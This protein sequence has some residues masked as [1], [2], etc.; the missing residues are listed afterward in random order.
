MHSPWARANAAL[1]FFG[2]A[3]AVLC[4]LTALTDFAHVGDP[5]ISLQLTSVKRLAPHRGGSDQAVLG[6]S[7]DADLRPAFGWNTKQLF[8][9]IRAE[10]KTDDNIVNEVV[11]WDRIV[12]SKDEAVLSIPS[13][14][15]KYAFLDRGSGLRG[16]DLTLTLAWNHMPRVGALLHASRS[17][18]AGRLPD[19]YVH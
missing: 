6:M 13:V 10:Y 14:K 7:L 15:H 11:L 12:R 3:A 17:F 8:V 9:F 1:T 16:R 19:E 4:A 5:R 2:S 18:P